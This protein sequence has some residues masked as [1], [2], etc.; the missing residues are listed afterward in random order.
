MTAT[1]LLNGREETRSSTLIDKGVKCIIVIYSAHE[2]LHGQL[3]V[4]CYSV[5]DDGN[6]T[7][8]S[9]NEEIGSK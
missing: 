7:N 8:L 3:P 2:F 9:M 6:L 4:H 1:E 5:E